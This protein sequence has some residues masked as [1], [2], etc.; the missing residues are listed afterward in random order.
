MKCLIGKRKFVITIFGLV[1]YFFLL[2]LRPSL[3]AWSVA[4]GI[5]IIL[6][7]FVYGNVKEYMIK[8]NENKN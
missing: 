7:A 8:Q 2:L 6:G 3:D 5:T 1:V 4:A